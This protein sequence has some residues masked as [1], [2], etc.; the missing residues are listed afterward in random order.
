MPA[1]NA[2]APRV[3]LPIDGHVVF[4][5]A[6]VYDRLVA[7]AADRGATLDEFTRALFSR[8]RRYTDAAAWGDP[9]ER[10]R[11]ARLLIGEAIQPRAN[12]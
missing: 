4:I 3:S 6:S 12:H 10:N 9:K 11:R 1:P 5:S 7:V 8:D 2:N